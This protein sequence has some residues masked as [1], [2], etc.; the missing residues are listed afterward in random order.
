MTPDI[1]MSFAVQSNPGVYAL[2][3]GSGISR[4]AGIPTGWEVVLDL[5]RKLAAAQDAD[6]EP[7]P[8]LWYEQTYGTQP[9]YSQLLDALAKTPS[10]RQQILRAYFEPNGEEQQEGLK[11]PTKAHRAIAKLVAKGYIRVILTT[12]FDRLMERALEDEG[13]APVVIS[14]ADQIQGAVPLPHMRC[15]VVKLHGDYLDTRILNTP[16]ELASYDDR[17]NDYLSRVFDEFG[18][19]ACGW[20]AE[21]DDALR[22]SIERI[23][24][25]RYTT[26]FAAVGTLGDRASALMKH[27]SGI[28]VPISNADAFFENLQTK[29]EAIEAFSQRHPLSTKAAV[30]ACKRFLSDPNIYRIRLADLVNDEARRVSEELKSAEL[31]NTSEAITSETVTTRVQRYDAMCATLCALAFQI[32]RWGDR[33][34]IEYLAEAQKRLY[35]TQTKQ[36][37]TFWIAYQGYPVSVISYAAMLG[38]SLQERIDVVGALLTNELEYSH[39]ETTLAIEAIPPFF[40]L[41]NE[42]WGKYLEGMNDKKA[43]LNEWLFKKL[44]GDFH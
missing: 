7:D 35:A 27:R 32:G 40:W 43:P 4:A 9:G 22:G 39:D 13:I 38:A 20:S 21:W 11:A 1:T 16:E 24:N 28:H 36:G 42:S 25:R 31:A 26:F 29:V 37:S 23:T 41:E 18:L 12:N 19:I 33:E 6:C 10:E 5:V 15:C 14:H 8:A 17:F 30:A 2:L 44:Y 34:S 3:L